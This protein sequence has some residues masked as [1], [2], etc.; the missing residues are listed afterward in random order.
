M[1]IKRSGEQSGRC[2]NS[3]DRMNSDYGIAVGN[4]LDDKEAC[5]QPLMEGRHLVVP[6][7][8]AART[9]LPIAA[10]AH[11]D[12]EES[13]CGLDAPRPARAVHCTISF[14]NVLIA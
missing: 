6:Y 2:I 7:D 11:L 14:D 10:I 13:D 5:S 4:H 12:T 9:K 1:S 8:S 3:L